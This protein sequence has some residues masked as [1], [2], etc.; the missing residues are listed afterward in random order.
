MS[1]TYSKSDSWQM[2]VTAGLSDNQRSKS[3]TL[4]GGLVQP[5]PP[6]VLSGIFLETIQF[7]SDQISRVYI[8]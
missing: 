6:A 3:R 2:F 7:R 5:D 8:K 1:L 4:V